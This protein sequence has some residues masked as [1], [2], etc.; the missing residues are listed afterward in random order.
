[1]NSKKDNEIEMNPSSRRFGEIKLLSLPFEGAIV[2]SGRS[3][4]LYP[5]GHTINWKLLL[6]YDSVYTLSS[7]PIEP[8]NPSSR[9]FGEFT[10]EGMEEEGQECEISI[11]G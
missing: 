10:F 11:N 2:I 9:H 7:G 5:R 1:M 6:R 8:K 3:W 4:G